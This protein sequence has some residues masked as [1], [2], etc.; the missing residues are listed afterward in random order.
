MI[1]EMKKKDVEMKKQWEGFKSGNWRHSSKD[2]KS[3]V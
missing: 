3:V 1:Y 2:R